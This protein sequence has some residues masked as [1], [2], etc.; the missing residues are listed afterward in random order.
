MGMSQCLLGTDNGYILK[1]TG[2]D[3]FK[4]VYADDAGDPKD[5]CGPGVS[6]PH[7]NY[8]M[9]CSEI[10]TQYTDRDKVVA[11]LQCGMNCPGGVAWQ[12]LQSSPDKGENWPTQSHIDNYTRR[13]YVATEPPFDNLGQHWTGRPDSSVGLPSTNT[14]AHSRDWRGIKPWLDTGINALTSPFL[15]PGTAFIDRGYIWSSRLSQSGG[16]TILGRTA[17]NG[18]GATSF[19]SATHVIGGSCTIR[20]LYDI[21]RLFIWSFDSNDWMAVIDI[22]DPTAPIFNWVAPFPSNTRIHQVQA[23]DAGHVVA[24]CISRFDGIP[25]SVSNPEIAVCS[26]WASAD[27]GLTWQ[28]KV[29]PD[30]VKLIMPSTTPTFI[31]GSVAS[32]SSLRQNSDNIN[33][34]FDHPNEVWVATRYPYVFRST[35][36]GETWSYEIVSD[37]LFNVGAIPLWFFGVGCVDSPDVITTSFR[38]WVTLIGTT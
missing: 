8:S 38:R 20:G 33:F 6:N 11:L 18:S 21:N 30:P 37:A 24:L 27:G 29:A 7:A 34:S 15:L 10:F 14:W 19:N 2:H 22:T 3:T 13:G 32:G 28:M 36:Y 31:S 35:D 5:T 12:Y 4:I 26:I 17:V 25:G 16:V 9:I 1:R 23:L